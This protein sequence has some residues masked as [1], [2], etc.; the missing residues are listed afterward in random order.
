MTYNHSLEQTWHAWDC[1][2]CCHWL[3]NELSYTCTWW[4]LNVAG[5]C[6]IVLRRHTRWWQNSERL[7]TNRQCMAFCLQWQ[8]TRR[9]YSSA[10]SIDAYIIPTTPQRHQSIVDWIHLCV[11]DNTEQRILRVTALTKPRQHCSDDLSLPETVSFCSERLPMKFS[12]TPRLWSGCPFIERSSTAN[13]LKNVQTIIIIY[14]FPAENALDIARLFSFVKLCKIRFLNL[15][16]DSK[17]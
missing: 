12:P 6:W 16:H 15:Y 1:A 11:I 5:R 2:V 13:F 9:T 14:S 8:C 10:I 7:S 4:R 17:N 3:H